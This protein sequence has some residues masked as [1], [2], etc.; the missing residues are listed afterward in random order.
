MRKYLIFVLLVTVGAAL[1]YASLSSIGKFVKVSDVKNFAEGR[2][3]DLLKASVHVGEVRVGFLD[4]ISLKGLKI[5]QEVKNKAFYLLDVD[6]VV[7]KYNLGRFWQ[8]DFKNPNTVLLDSPQFTFQSASFMSGLQLTKVLRE[9]SRLTD[10]LEFKEGKVALRAPW[11]DAHCDITDIQGKLA[12]LDGNEWRVDL[13]A[14]VR[15]LFEGSLAVKGTVDLDRAKMALQLSLNHLKSTRP[16][17][18]VKAISGTI[19]VT[20]DEI[21]IQKVT[22]EYNRLPVE[23]SGWIKQFS[24]SPQLD[25]RVGIGRDVLR[26]VFQINGGLDGSNLSGKIQLPGKE[27]PVTGKLTVDGTRF[28]LENVR[29]AQF[30]GS[31]GQFDFLKGTFHFYLEREN[32]RIDLGLNLKD[33]NIG[34]LTQLDH[35]PFFGADLVTRAHFR[36]QPD[37]D[38]WKKNEWG[39]NGSIKT[40]YLVLDQAPFPDFEGEFHAVPSR[41]ELLDFHWGEGYG[42]AGSLGLKP[43]FLLDAAVTLKGI[44]L[45]ELKSV[46]ARPLPENF[47]GLADGEVK[48]KGENWKA[49][50]EGD[51]TVTEGSIGNIDY[52]RVTLHFYGLPPYLKLKDSRLKKGLRTFYLDGGLDV[53]SDNVF[54]DVRVASSEKILLWSGKELTTS[55]KGSQAAKRRPADADEE[56][57]VTVGPRFHF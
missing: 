56:D 11:F 17:F 12:R 18:P 35:M 5:N 27:V 51:I 13:E 31:Q 14:R 53:S 2:L 29:I 23:V 34:F 8:R 54:H 15:D 52:D 10:E 32:Q 30:Y 40:D 46:F 24:T 36:L 20:A 7:F 6:K 47:K 21:H 37:P 33:W 3:G 48:L 19:M 57:T 41:L 49:E 22:F 1:L 43:P 9:G 50:V 44:Q 4:Q 38:L 45:A 28:S 26:S 25:I 42:L 16:D 55:E 39:F